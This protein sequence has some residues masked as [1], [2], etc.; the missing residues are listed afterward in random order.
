MPSR[1]RR[2][3]PAFERRMGCSTTPR[4]QVSGSQFAWPANSSSLLFSC[5]GVNSFVHL[6]L[7]G[8]SESVF[9]DFMERH[10]IHGNFFDTTVIELVAFSQKES[11][12]LRIGNH[13]DHPVGCSHNSIQPQRANLQS[14]F[15]RRKGTLFTALLL[16]YQRFKRIAFGNFWFFVGRRCRA[17]CRSYRLSWCGLP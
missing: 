14:R 3:A 8:L 9:P 6:T 4:S 11:A 12:R 7:H 16:T 2:Q 1:S 10:S 5:T 15:T 17:G 13:G